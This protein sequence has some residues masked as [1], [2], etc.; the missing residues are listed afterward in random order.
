MIND[1]LTE[2]DKERICIEIHRY[3]SYVNDLTTYQKETMLQFSL[4][5]VI[6][7]KQKSP[8]I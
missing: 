3:P 6:L 4:L 8:P 2:R 7:N 5:I 1:I